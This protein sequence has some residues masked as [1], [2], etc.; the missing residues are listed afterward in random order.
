MCPEFF[1][2]GPLAIRPY[3]VT[4][5]LSFFIGLA[6]IHRE[7]KVL[8]IDPD[9][10]V[11]LGAMGVPTSMKPRIEELTLLGTGTA[12]FNIDL[13]IGVEAKLRTTVKGSIS[14]SGA[15]GEKTKDEVDVL[16][17]DANSLRR[18]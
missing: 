17:K 6:L 13:G 2:I 9:R 1:H 16:A 18:K 8:R 11:N 7:A 10:A 3:G 4:L 14:L 5:A 15:Q 12:R